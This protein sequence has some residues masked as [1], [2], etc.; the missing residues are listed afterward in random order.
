[1][2]LTWASYSFHLQHP[3]STQAVY[4][5]FHLPY[6]QPIIRKQVCTKSLINPS[7]MFDKTSFVPILTKSSRV[8]K[9]H[10][11]YD[12]DSAETKPTCADTAK[13]LTI[14]TRCLT[15]EIIRSLITSSGPY[16]R[17]SRLVRLVLTSREFHL[18][19]NLSARHQDYEPVQ[20]SGWFLLDLCFVYSSTVPDRKYKILFFKESRNS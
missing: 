7:G 15:N 16:I 4:F 17:K 10:F 2:G 11:T 6:I 3:P 12:N 1:M 18:P 19:R 5:S 8:D 14:Y 13:Q 20:I 9:T